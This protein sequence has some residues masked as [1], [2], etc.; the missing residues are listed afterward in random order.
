VKYQILIMFLISAGTG[1][2]TLAAVSIGS[3]QLFDERQRLCLE[4]LRQP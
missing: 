3:K 1:L 2:G 4:R